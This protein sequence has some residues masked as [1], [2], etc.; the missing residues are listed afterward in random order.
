MGIVAIA[1]ATHSALGYLFS[2]AFGPD[3][4]Y[5]IG[6]LVLLGISL[7]LYYSRIKY[8]KHV[9]VLWF[10]LAVNFFGFAQGPYILGGSASINSYLTTGSMAFYVNLV[11]LIGGTIVV[12]SLA[13]M[14]YV[15]YIKK[16]QGATGSY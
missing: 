10:L 5:L 6:L 16:A 7:Y 14:I 4:P 8:A 3:L 11:T 2:A 1:I 15:S 13:F 9:A 12:V